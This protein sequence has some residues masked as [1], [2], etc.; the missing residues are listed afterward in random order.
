MGLNSYVSK[1]PRALPIF[2]L[3]DASGSMRGEKINELNLALREMLNALNNV[4]DI[5][6]KFQLCVISF[7]GDVKVVQPLADV[8][9]MMLP[10]L[11][12]SGNTP[13]G[14]AFEVVKEMIE[15][16]E[17]VSSRAYAPTIVL[18]SDG[19]PTDCSEEI[20]NNKKYDSWDALIDL[21]NGE[22]SSKSQRLALGIGADADY[23]MLKEYI[24]NPEIPVIKA[25]DA[26]GITKFFKWVTMSTVARMNSVNPNVT[27]IVASTFDM[28]EEDILI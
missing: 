24:N 15:D 25:N 2:V 7:G 19:I 9:G 27:S 6:G 1:E 18:I 14:E 3:A 26:T 11:T 13:M 4:E 28:D 23:T 8:E 10:E 17:I 21:H 20:Y 12:A 16:R 22:R 5:R